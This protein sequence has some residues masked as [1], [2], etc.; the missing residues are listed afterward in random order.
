MEKPSKNILWFDEIAIEDVPKVGGKNA[1]LGEM[2]K[3]VVPQG[4]NVPYGFATTAEA[5]FYF[6]ASTGLDKK[7]EEVLKDLNIQDLKQL[8]QK[9]KQVREMI[10]AAQFP[11]EFANEVVEAYKKLS[12]R[13]GTACNRRSGAIFGNGRRFAGSQFCR[14]AGN[15]FKYCRSRKCFGGFEKMFCFAF[16]RQGNCLPAANGIFTHKSW[17]VCRNSKNGAKRFGG[18]GSYVFL[19]YGIGIW[20]RCFDKCQ[21]WI[22]RKYCAGNC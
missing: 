12:E 3:A 21:L 13:Y 4:V 22:G 2:T 18:I 14:T 7:I 9:G 15:L 5:Y 16:Y 19:R 11:Q 17:I 20:R 6:F 1:S 10:V 8:A